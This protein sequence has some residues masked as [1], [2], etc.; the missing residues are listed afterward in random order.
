MPEFQSRLLITINELDNEEENAFVFEVNY[1]VPLIAI[2][3]YY[4]TEFLLI[5]FDVG[6]FRFSRRIFGETLDSARQ[7]SA[8]RYFGEMMTSASR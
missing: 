4:L 3:I 2:H 1:V 6:D 7:Y 5:K 8:R